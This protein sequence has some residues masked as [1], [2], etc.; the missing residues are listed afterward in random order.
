MHTV[1]HGAVGR[2]MLGEDGWSAAS[3]LGLLDRLAFSY[4]A[5]NARE[6]RSIALVG[7]RPLLEP[8][9]GAPDETILRARNDLSLA[10]IASPAASRCA[11]AL[12]D[13]FTSSRLL[14]LLQPF[15]ISIPNNQPAALIHVLLLCAR[16]PN[17]MPCRSHYTP[18]TCTGRHLLNTSGPINFRSSSHHCTASSEYPHGPVD[19]NVLISHLLQ[20][21]D[22]NP[23]LSS[24]GT[25]YARS[26]SSST[27]LLFDSSDD[28]S[29]FTPAAS[30]PHSL[31]YNALTGCSFSDATVSL[32][33]DDAESFPQDEGAGPEDEAPQEQP[34]SSSRDISTRN[35]SGKSFNPLQES[36][37][38]GYLND[39]WTRAAMEKRARPRPLSSWSDLPSAPA[40]TEGTSIVSASSCET[41]ARKFRWISESSSEY[42]VLRTCAM[43]RLA[44]EALA[45]QRQQLLR[46]EAYASKD[47][48]SLRTERQCPAPT[49]SA[50]RKMRSIGLLRWRLQHCL[51]KLSRRQDPCDRGCAN[52]LARLLRRHDAALNALPANIHRR[53]SQERCEDV[54]ASDT[55]FL[56]KKKILH[57]SVLQT[58]D[59]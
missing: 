1:G 38:V 10:S 54:N 8:R 28:F 6:A 25:A 43:S 27:S 52:A 12:A 50:L 20:S 23:A 11:F 2:G 9:R 16:L 57:E 14:L 48:P 39:V 53:R 18:I 30:C 13:F 58:Q 15:S 22:N 51:T 24:A 37:E 42:H 3:L 17:G 21:D 46:L 47:H 45:G 40:S 29:G 4:G 7:V 32:D 55:I 44:R 19:N 34:S 31:K 49:C 41:S 5:R 35:N 26:D 36:I 33:D 56:F 59:R